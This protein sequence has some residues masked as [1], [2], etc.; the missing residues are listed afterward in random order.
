[1]QEFNKFLR[2]SL[3]IDDGDTQ[4]VMGTISTEAVGFATDSKPKV[5]SAWGGIAEM[6]NQL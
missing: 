5:I 2:K 6:C 4:P 3:G 1:M